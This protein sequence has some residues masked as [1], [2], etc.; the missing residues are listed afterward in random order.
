[1][2]KNARSEGTTDENLNFWVA[3]ESL[4][5]QL[6]MKRFPSIGV[7]VPQDAGLITCELCVV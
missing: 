1:M 3:L 2:R 5:T 6:D 7:P 4:I